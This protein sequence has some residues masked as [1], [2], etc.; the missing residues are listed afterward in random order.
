M[1][2][3]VHL[4]LFAKPTQSPSE[5]MRLLRGTTA[6]QLFKEFPWL[7]RKLWKGHLW[8]PSYYVGTAGQ[9]LAETIKKNIQNQK[10]K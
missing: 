1:P 5:L 7:R 4:F 2:D 8:N 10:T 9:M 6:Y 3:H